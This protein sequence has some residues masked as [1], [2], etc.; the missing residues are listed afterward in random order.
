[1]QGEYLL[2]F[3][4]FYI[5][6]VLKIKNKKIMKKLFS[7]L[8]FVSFLFSCDCDRVLDDPDLAWSIGIVNNAILKERTVALEFRSS[9]QVQRVEFESFWKFEVNGSI[10]SVRLLDSDFTWEQRGNVLRGVCKI[11]LGS[12]LSNPQVRHRYTHFV[13]YAVIDGRRV[14]LRN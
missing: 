1:L 4:A 2:T 5:Y 8:V 13:G 12:L 9:R 7:L 6:S 14:R 10:L 3:C 11:P